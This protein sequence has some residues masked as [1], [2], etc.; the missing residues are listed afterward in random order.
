MR[1]NNRAQE[2]PLLIDARAR[3]RRS[4]CAYA[5]AIL[6]AALTLQLTVAAGNVE[7]NSSVISQ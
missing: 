7:A 4:T 3:T 1:N 5:I 6:A 2:R